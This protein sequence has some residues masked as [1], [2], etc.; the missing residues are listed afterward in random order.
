MTMP[1]YSPLTHEEYPPR[2]C[3]ECG[4]DAGYMDVLMFLR[5]L[6]DGYVCQVCSSYYS[7]INGE[8]KKMALVI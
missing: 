8:L 3:P 7:E 2:Y 5:I 6:P 1:E 4:R